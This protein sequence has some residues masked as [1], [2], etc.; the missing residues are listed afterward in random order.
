MGKVLPG[1]TDPHLQCVT[2][3]VTTLKELLSD[4]EYAQ[5]V[6]GFH[7]SSLNVD[8]AVLNATLTALCIHLEEELWQTATQKKQQFVRVDLK[9][10]INIKIIAG[11]RDIDI[12]SAPQVQEYT[13]RTRHDDTLDSLCYVTKEANGQH[14][15]RPAGFGASFETA[16]VDTCRLP[17]AGEVELGETAKKLESALLSA[18]PMA[19]I[20]K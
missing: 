5:N 4:L 17:L 18:M 13:Y 10:C 3:S 9:A 19:R 6:S 15:A 14:N 20:Q 16:W 7:D 2:P 1:Y 11:G 8:T 12:H